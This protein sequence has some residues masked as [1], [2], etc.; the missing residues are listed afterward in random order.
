MKNLDFSTGVVEYIVNGGTTIRFNPADSAFVGR[1]HQAFEGLDK[2][3][4]GYLA[5]IDAMQDNRQIFQFAQERDK[6][7]RAVIDSVFEA[8]VSDSIFGSLN[9]YALADGLPLWCNFLLAVMDEVDENVS[10]QQ[11][12]TSPR[13]ERYTAKYRKHQKK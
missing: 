3:Q 5:E 12:L 13:V 11:K 6:E 4:E 10:K 7:M 8:P 2:K 9:V 1:L